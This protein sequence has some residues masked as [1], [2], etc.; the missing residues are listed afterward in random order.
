MDILNKLLEQTP[1]LCVNRTAR[2]DVEYSDVNYDCV[3]TMRKIKN[4]YDIFD[5]ECGSSRGN[6]NCSFF[7]KDGFHNLNLTE[8]YGFLW[9]NINA[10]WNN[11]QIE[12]NEYGKSDLD[13]QAQE[14]STRAKWEK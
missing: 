6:A 2:V 7:Y 11:N 1:L 3:E 4:Y 10:Q 12:I 13:Y 14:S 9:F 8:R 5:K